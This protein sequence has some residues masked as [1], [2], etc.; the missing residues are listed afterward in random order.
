M[1]RCYVPGDHSAS[2][3]FFQREIHEIASRDYS[4]VR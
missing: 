2:A 1:I 4:E 3:E